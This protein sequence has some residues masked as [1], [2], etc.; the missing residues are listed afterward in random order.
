MPEDRG[1]GA[2]RQRV[3][4]GLPYPL[5]AT[6]DG[7]G[8]NFA[9][10]SA[11][12][13]R[14]ELS[15]FDSSGT[16]EISRV[17]FT[18]RTDEV[19]HA[20]LPYARPGMLYGYRVYGPYDPGHGHRFNHHKLLLDPYAK[21]LFGHLRWSDAHFGYRI[22]SPREDLSFDR[23]DNAHGMPKCVLVDPAFSW[24]S[25]RHLATPW[26]GTVVYEVHARG[27]TMLHPD[28][29]APL[30]GTF[31]GFGTPEI[32]RH[33]TQLGVTAVEFLP[34]HAFIDDRYL[35]EKGL[36]NYWGYNSIGFFAPEPRYAAT[37]KI[38]EFKEMVARLHDAGIEVILD[39]VYNHT[40][41]GNHLGPTLSFKGIDNASY[42]RL[43]PDDRRYYQDFTGCGN[44]LNLEHPRVLQMVMD[45]VR[46]WVEEMHVDG[47]RFDL[48]TALARGPHGYNEHAAFLQA[49]RQDPVL[50]RVKLI[51]EPWDIGP[52][53]YQ[54]GNFPPGW[55]EWNDRFR[56]TARRFWR[57]DGGVIG[58]VAR[59]VTGSADLFE[60]RGRRPWASI[61]FV[62]AHD[63]FTLQDLVS[64]TRKHNESNLEENRDGVSENF[65]WN[66][67]VEGPT[68][69]P[70]IKAL[71]E[72]SKRNMLAM[73]LLSLGVPMLV[74]GDEMG[75]SQRGNNN[76]YCQDNDVGW[77]KWPD[78][79]DVHQAQLIDFVRMLVAFRKKYKWPHGGKFLKGSPVQDG[80]QKDVTWLRLD[81]REMKEADW[82]DPESRFIAL[83]LWGELTRRHHL[84]DT[85]VEDEAPVILAL[86]A[87]QDD[88][89]FI[90]P[91]VES[92]E[93]WLVAFDTALPFGTG[94]RRAL[95]GGEQGLVKGRS[96]I[97]LVGIAPAGTSGTA[98]NL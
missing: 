45:S 37:K 7:K 56:D 19:W 27:Y 86:N 90:A 73:L 72:Q 5:G 96:M 74:A 89:P 48:T 68:G 53:G 76:P 85:A 81:G 38:E 11:N 29:P 55:S 13:E 18:E 44:A 58:D 65:S 33:L 95:S 3:E 94:A 66:H 35:V 87:H 21:A 62:T 22:G 17:L 50:S 79:D 34:I 67:G 25:D 10:F 28:I 61:N 9:L 2:S 75:N 57:G 39:V 32:I 1:S 82:H 59:R 24:G 84:T 77:T 64:Y 41:E 12:A 97:V 93:T 46:Y 78:P 98:F 26:A 63:G 15:I 83:M 51:A 4:P 8:A 14:V 91:H 20:Y 30:R 54:L 43:I 49:V 70:A 52:G 71:R 23:R 92:V 16:R 60:Q 88:M 69:D 80:K 40:A 42:Y 31:A 47:F 6:W 36:R